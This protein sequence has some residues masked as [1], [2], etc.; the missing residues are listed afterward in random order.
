MYIHCNASTRTD[1][2]GDLPG[3]GRVWYCPK[4]IANILPLHNVSR[5]YQAEFKSEED[6]RFV[7]AKDDGK[8]NMFRV[9][10]NGLYYYDAKAAAAVN[11][12]K[13]SCTNAEVSK[14]EFARALQQKLG[15]VSKAKFI[16]IVTNNILPNYPLT[17]RDIMAAEDI[18]GPDLGLVKGKATTHGKQLN[19]HTIASIGT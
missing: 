11:D 1:Q 2:Q 4:A 8:A 14:G 17:E 16:R 9:L 19:V 3:Y 5:G 6:N 13:T 15:H 18:Y 7:V 12:N 10:A